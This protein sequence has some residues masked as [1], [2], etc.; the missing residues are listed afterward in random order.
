MEDL[1]T[2]VI[3]V[4]NGEKFIKKCI[5]SVVNQTYINLEILIINDGSIDNTL[6]ICESYKDERIRIINQ[7][8]MGLSLARNV[9]IEN[10]KGKYLYFVDVDDFIE[11]DTIEYLYSLIKKYNVSISTCKPIDIY[12]YNVKIENTIEKITLIS[13]KDMLKKILLSQDRAGTFW[14]KLYKKDL[15]NNI[16]FEDRIIN[17]ATV[18]YKLI[19]SVDE[20]VYSNQVKYYYLRHSQSITGKNAGE[21]SIDLYNVAIERY[22]HIKKVYPDFIEN[23]IGLILIIML[24]YLNEEQNVQKFLKDHKVKQFSR[25]L[26]SFKILIS[27]ISLKEKIKICLFMI[28]TKLYKIFA[29]KYQSINYKYKM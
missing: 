13:N 9:G 23:E 14:N 20:I 3:N 24:V 5:D 26:F 11:S 17:D 4:Y 1:I 22:N 19:L 2:I 16:R 6:K 21:R 7:E 10:A 29:K 18:M 8:N 25:K 27:T 28:N 15:F 12:D